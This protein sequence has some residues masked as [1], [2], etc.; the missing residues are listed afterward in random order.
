MFNNQLGNELT[1]ALKEKRIKVRFPKGYKN[2]C[3]KFHSALRETKGDVN[4][5]LERIHGKLPKPG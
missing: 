2:W 4:K 1:K 5:A 3:N